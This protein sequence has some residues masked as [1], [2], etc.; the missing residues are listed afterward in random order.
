MLRGRPGDGA[1]PG[2]AM[3][4]TGP[5]D[6][7]AGR[8]ALGAVTIL[9]A[10]LAIVPSPVRGQTTAPDF[11]F[12]P[13]TFPGFNGYLVRGGLQSC[14][15]NCTGG[16]VEPKEQV[17][18]DDACSTWIYTSDQL[19]V[20]AVNGFA[21]TVN[22]EVL[23]LPPGVTSQTAASVTIDP[24]GSLAAT[25]FSLK[26][27]ASVPLGTFTLTVRGTSGTLVHSI[28]YEITV[29]DVLPADFQPVAPPGV[30]SIAVFSQ[31]DLLLGAP[32]NVVGGTSTTGTVFLSDGSPFPTNV[33]V[34][35]S[36][37][38]P[39]LAT[40]SP[41]SLAIP[42][43]ATS[44]SFVVSTA[45]VS[46]SVLVSISASDGTTMP[47]RSVDIWPPDS[48]S[49]TRAQY[50]LAKRVLAVEAAYSGT[51]ATF[52]GTLTV[53]VTA[54]GATIGTLPY[55]G[56]STFKGQLSWPVNPQTITVRSIEGGSDTVNVVAK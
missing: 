20:V 26:A 51:A 41:T 56:G 18:L 29:V 19:Q 17:C 39:A 23:N 30:L 52:T 24:G 11:R 48:V 21:G 50:D 2:S 34:A 15:G 36:S 8:A 31:F 55:A 37:S 53:S 42:A 35:L 46:A 6:A 1:H 7:A 22:L 16:L 40:V 10:L 9:V 25:P 5:L 44:A 47:A 28:G 38:D 4:E 49:V 54:T 33:T 14:T 45:P 13:T 43:G 3:N 12:Q 32:P 27:D